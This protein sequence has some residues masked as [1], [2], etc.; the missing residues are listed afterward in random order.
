LR[1]THRSVRESARLSH[2]GFL[3]GGTRLDAEMEER[4]LIHRL[5][6]FGGDGNAHAAAAQQSHWAERELPVGH[7]RS[8]AGHAAVAEALHRP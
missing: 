7:H 2:L 8:V 6:F 4:F 1:L 3:S 5:D